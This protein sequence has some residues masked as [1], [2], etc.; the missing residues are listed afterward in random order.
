MIATYDEASNKLTDDVYASLRATFGA[1]LS[2]LPWR[3]NY[4]LI[5][6]VGGTVLAEELAPTAATEVQA[7]WMHAACPSP[8]PPLP[9]SPPISSC[10]FRVESDCCSGCAAP[11]PLPHCPLPLR[12][13]SRCPLRA[14]QNLNLNLTPPP[15]RR[16]GWLAARPTRAST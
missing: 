14:G 8:P 2:K 1:S 13:P 7:E 3:T 9:A 6:V 16:L 4:A 12:P 11:Q 5:A 10:G 15:T